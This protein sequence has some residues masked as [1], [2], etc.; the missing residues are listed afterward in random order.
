[1]TK[2]TI[3]FLLLSIIG[4]VILFFGRLGFSES[5]EP[6]G[7]YLADLLNRIGSIV[8][9]SSTLSTD[10]IASLQKLNPPVADSVINTY[11]NAGGDPDVI[12]SE[13]KTYLS[14]CP[15]APVINV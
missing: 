9:D 12:I 14:S 8:Y 6:S 2:K 4:V 1:M 10:K 13:I 5:F 7:S 15:H 11:L 3:L